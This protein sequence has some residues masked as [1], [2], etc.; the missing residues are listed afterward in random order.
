MDAAASAGATDLPGATDLA[1]ADIPS[2]GDELLRPS[3]IYTPAVRAA[4][5]SGGIH[6]VAHITGGGFVGNL[7]RMLPDGLKATLDRGSW[8]VPPLFNEI[9]RLGNVSAGEMARVFNLGLGMVMAVDPGCVDSALRALSDAGM[10]AAVVGRV[11]PAEDEAGRVGTGHPVVE[12]AGPGWWPDAD[13]PE[14]SG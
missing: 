10:G 14:Q 9:R 12:F 3:I 13:P 7:P 4:V 11:Y 5:S 1:G 8:E 6:A 2:L